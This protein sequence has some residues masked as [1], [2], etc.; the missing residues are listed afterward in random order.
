MKPRRGFKPHMEGG[1]NNKQPHKVDPPQDEALIDL[2]KNLSIDLNNEG[3]E[4]K[5][6]TATTRPQPK[7][8]NAAYDPTKVAEEK[9]HS[10]NVCQHQVSLYF[11]FLGRNRK[12]TISPL[13]R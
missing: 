7:S 11:S 3:A 8:P 5:E 1:P 4:R 6:E 2:P 13:M 12:F 10:I 9:K